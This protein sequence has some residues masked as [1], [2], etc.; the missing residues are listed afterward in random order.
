[1]QVHGKTLFGEI[2]ATIDGLRMTVPD[3]MTNRHRQMIAEWEEAGNTI[4]AYAPPPPSGADV[5]A[6]RERR[7]A[8]GTTV[9]ITGYGT[10]PLQGRDVD[11]I[12]LLG[13]VQA[14]SLRVAAGDVT[15]TTVFRD[16]DN[17]N[18]ELTPPQII[19]LWSKGSAW[20]SSVYTASWVIKELSPIPA[21]FSDDARWP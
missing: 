12:N 15:T 18:H 8:A 9:N 1:M 13:L 2:D 14:A 5:N 7:I 3:D 10:I 11:Q 21:D 6:E 16:A 20:I 17:T 19:E 4:P